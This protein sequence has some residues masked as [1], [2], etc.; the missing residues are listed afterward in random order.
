MVCMPPHLCAMDF[1][2]LPLVHH[3]LSSGRPVLQLSLFDPHNYRSKVRMCASGKLRKIRFSKVLNQKFSNVSG[4]T[5]YSNLTFREA[6]W[7]STRFHDHASHRCKFI[8]YCL[9][10]AEHPL[11]SHWN[12]KLK[13]NKK[14]FLLQTYIMMAK[15]QCKN[16]SAAIT[17]NSKIKNTRYIDESLLHRFPLLFILIKICDRIGGCVQREIYM[18]SLCCSGPTHIYWQLRLNVLLTT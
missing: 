12:L 9:V 13:K 7:N 2:N 4:S 5:Q 16:R 8:E 14:K 11:F 18:Y 15:V 6:L 17:C 10:C 1:S 3:L